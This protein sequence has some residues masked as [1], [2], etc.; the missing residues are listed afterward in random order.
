ML[1][2]IWLYDGKPAISI[3][4]ELGHDAS[5][6]GTGAALRILHVPFDNDMWFRYISWPVAEMKAEQKYSSDEGTAIYDNASRQSLILGS[7]THDSEIAFRSLTRIQIIALADEARA[8]IDAID[9]DSI[10]GLRDSALIGLMVY[11]TVVQ[12]ARSS[13]RRRS[14]MRDDRRT[15]S[16]STAMQP[17]IEPY[18]R[19]ARR[20]CCQNARIY[21][22]RST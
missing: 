7:I 20:A 11:T 3:E 8:L 1:Q 5:E 13:S 12:I 9:T 10:P 2:H 15:R 6:I 16:L 19:C 18:A 17:R 21:A 22:P 4:A 14:G